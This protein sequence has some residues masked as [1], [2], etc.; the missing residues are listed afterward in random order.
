MTL[1]AKKEEVLN[2]TN[3]IISQTVAQSILA[4][5]DDPV[6]LSENI[7][8]A[9]HEGI[10]V[11]FSSMSERY[12]SEALGAERYG[13]TSE[14]T[15]LR[16]G[17]R[18]KHY[19]TTWGK[20]AVRVVK[21][22]QGLLLP[23]VLRTRNLALNVAERVRALW[24]DG[25]STRDIARAS[26]EL[27]S[28]GL[29][30]VSHTT[31][32]KT[33]R[34]VSE[35]VLQWLNRPVRQDIV[36]LSLDAKY[37]SILRETANKEPILVAVG[38][39]ADGHKE[40]LDIMPANS[41]SYDAWRTMLSRLR[42]RGMRTEQLRLVATDGNP[43]LIRA[44]EESLPKTRR[45]RCVVH[46]VR[47]VMG[48]SPV[49]LKSVAPKEAS[50]I[51]KAPNRDEAE[52]RAKQFIEKYAE[53]HP[54]LADII[55]DDL[56][57]TLSFYALDS[58]VW[59]SLKSTNVQERINRELKRKFLEIGALKGETAAT[60]VAVMLAI[61]HNELTRNDIVKGF[62]KPRN[63]NSKRSAHS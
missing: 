25:L 4:G 33:I 47:N 51:W 6:A 59:K 32:A 16:S 53:S 14:R 43:G 15:G 27:S 38:I 17:Y 46:K 62:K 40:I 9:I 2:S 1:I 8:H 48:R 28:L 11:A 7:D 50:E 44:V 42:N 63:K 10:A 41:E 22:R 54:K 39:T 58:K 24:V 29:G 13:R 36:Y 34:D 20:I 30:D 56:D 21:S 49:H 61:R 19:Q 18:T 31:V 60:R 37:V 3:Q 5:S 35:Q 26:S 45:Q 23:P 57:A 52:E 12:A 55:R